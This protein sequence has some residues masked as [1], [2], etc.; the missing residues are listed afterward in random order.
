[1]LN[2]YDSKTKVDQICN[3]YENIHENFAQKLKMEKRLELELPWQTIESY[4]DVEFLLEWKF[5]F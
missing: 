1:V 5:C 3:D 2:Q 4:F